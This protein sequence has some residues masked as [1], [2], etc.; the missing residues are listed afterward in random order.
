MFALIQF[1]LEGCGTGDHS[2]RDEWET[3]VEVLVESTWRVSMGKHCP[4]LL[5]FALPVVVC[6]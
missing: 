5:E 4:F 3:R 6:Q 1:W 2:T